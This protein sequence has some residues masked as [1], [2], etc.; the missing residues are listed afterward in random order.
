MRSTV[1]EEVETP[2]AP[3]WAAVRSQGPQSSGRDS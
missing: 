3:A 1:I 2:V